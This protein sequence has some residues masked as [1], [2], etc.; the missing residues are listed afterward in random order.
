MI[1]KNTLKPA[2]E[3]FCKENGLDGAYVIVEKYAIDNTF[4]T[5]HNDLISRHEYFGEHISID[6]D[7]W[8]KSENPTV[9][10]NMYITLD[11]YNSVSAH[12]LANSADWTIVDEDSDEYGEFD[13]D[14]ETTTYSELPESLKTDLDLWWDE[15]TLD[16]ASRIEAIVDAIGYRDLEEHYDYVHYT[17][18]ICMLN[19]FF[20]PRIV[21]EDAAFTAMLKPFFYRSSFD[22]D[23]IFLLS[24]AGCGMD[25]SA[26]LDL[27]QALTSKTLPSD[28]Q[29][30]NVNN[31]DFFR[32]VCGMKAEDV[33]KM[34]ELPKPKI[35]FEAYESKET[36][37]VIIIEEGDNGY[38]MSFAGYAS[39]EAETSD[40]AVLKL[41][42]IGKEIEHLKSFREFSIEDI[43]VEGMSAVRYA[44]SFMGYLRVTA[45]N[46]GM[47]L[48]K[49]YEIIRFYDLE[50]EDVMFDD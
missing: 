10:S 33:L 38:E 39:L 16:K 29:A 24:L 19:T 5:L 12:C 9:P 3:Q 28:S 6:L 35:V 18:D 27:Y 23:E 11:V 43:N 37:K 14:L 2:F 30:F 45:S 7:K 50:A 47:A 31:Q 34:C 42:G 25:L 26:T 17:D 15:I 36:D 40:E 20:E 44:L 22:D 1:D 46:K 48:E 49:F 21:D 8:F 4:Y 13:G 32:S 41:R